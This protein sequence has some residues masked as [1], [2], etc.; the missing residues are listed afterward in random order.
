MNTRTQTQTKAAPAPSF[1][2]APSGL[3]QRQCACSGTFG[4]TGECAECS[5]KRLTVQRRTTNQA[6]ISAVPPIVHEV[7]HSPGQP[8]D[9]VTRAFMESRFGHDFRQVRVHSDARA[10]ESARAVSALA[11]TAG[12]EVV[13]GAGRY[14]PESGA[15]Q[16]LLAHE[17]THVVQQHAVSGS[18]SQAAVVGRAGDFS[19]REAELVA[20]RVTAGFST[21]AVRSLSEATIQRQP[22]E[23]EQSTKRPLTR[24]EE[25]ELSRTSPGQVT[26]SARPFVLSLYNFAINK[27]DLKELHEG[28]LRE[29]GDLLKRVNPEGLYA[30]ARGYADASGDPKGNNP[31]SLRRAEAVQARLATL[32]GIDVVS[33]GFGEEQPV[34]SNDTVEGRSRNRRVDIYFLPVRTEPTISPIPLPDGGG[35]RGTVIPPLPPPLPERKKR[36]IVE[37]P[38]RVQ[39]PPSTTT[40]PSGEQNPPQATEDQDFCD[41]YPILCGALGVGGILG[42]VVGGGL[43]GLGA[44]LLP[45]V[46]Y[47][48]LNPQDCIPGGPP[49]EPEPD[50][51][52]R[53]CVE[54]FAI[55][56]IDDQQKERKISDGQEFNVTE[57]RGKKAEFAFFAKITFRNDNSGCKC[58]CGEYQQEV[59]GWY[60]EN[61]IVKPKRLGSVL[62]HPTAFQEDINEE[63]RRYG[64]R[65]NPT[66]NSFAVDS[67]LPDR[68]TGCSYTSFDDPGIRR[69]EGDVTSTFS[70]ELTFRAGPVDACPFRAPVWS[71]RLIPGWGLIQWTV[72]GMGIPPPPPPRPGRIPK[73]PRLPSVKPPPSTPTTK[74]LLCVCPGEAGEIGCET[75][76]FLLKQL[77]EQG[78]VTE[79]QVREA[80]EREF[81][82]L[83]LIS[84]AS[85]TAEEEGLLL[86]EA[87]WRVES[88]LK[89]AHFPIEGT[90]GEA[91]GLGESAA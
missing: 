22:V 71:P 48:L 43:G 53:A 23:D 2:S 5:S 77:T 10:A 61:G 74:P 28:A 31:L 3:L 70:F 46:L 49:A 4:L 9:P 81:N 58:Q 91:E 51:P 26:G 69:K 11:Y 20:D 78:Q 75:E 34:A 56:W 6:E 63:G 7:L 39:P 68:P 41:E 42:G 66:F 90:E 79:A 59:K 62:L 52:D 76:D 36:E 16:K 72:K 65:H 40:P 55:F 8:L 57:G 88:Y 33:E 30:I 86:D 80:I 29:L 44:G 82:L 73:P 17:L 24:A 14:A 21:Q 85:L 18:F 37:P 32:A 84:N 15:G 19:E 47:C 87:Q 12:P 45:P 35:P 67:F 89:G 13:F 38:A 27:A 83:R 60:E 1:M 54:D 25:I 64:H 50:P